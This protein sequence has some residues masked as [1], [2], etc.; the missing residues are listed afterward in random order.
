LWWRRWKPR[1]KYLPHKNIVLPFL[2][3]RKPVSIFRFIIIFYIR[4]FYFPPPLETVF[5]VLSVIVLLSWGLIS[6]W[7]S[8]KAIWQR[9]FLR[10]RQ[11]KDALK[12]A[13]FLFVARGEDARCNAFFLFFVIFFPTSVK[14]SS[15]ANT[16]QTCVRELRISQ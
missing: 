12:A 8:H 6:A 4:H 13:C 15:F 7:R 1:I 14:S 10:L 2:L 3:P 16:C 11:A 5:L 9:V